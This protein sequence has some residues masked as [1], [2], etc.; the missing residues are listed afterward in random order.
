MRKLRYSI[1]FLLVGLSSYSSFGKIENEGSEDNGSV[2]NSVIIA[3]IN[4]DDIEVSIPFL[5]FSFRDAEIKLK[6]K[7]P[8]HTRLLFNKNKID[9]I[10]NGEEKE[11]NFINGE[12]S[13]LK[14][15]DSENALTIYAEGFGYN[16]SITA[17]SLW[18]ILLP[19]VLIIVLVVFLMMKKNK[20]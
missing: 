1:L 3:R 19:I 13:F 14:K 15:F 20:V 8:E 5:I 11:L 16:H 2:D 9:F 6:F 18:V 7:N 12:A 10:I 17:L 4:N